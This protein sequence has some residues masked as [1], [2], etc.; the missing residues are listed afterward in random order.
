MF[1]LR[2]KKIRDFDFFIS[3]KVSGKIEEDSMQE[4]YILIEFG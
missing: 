4:K 3:S 2:L 1:F